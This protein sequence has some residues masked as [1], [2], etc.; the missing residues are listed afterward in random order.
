ML[1]DAQS[2]LWEGCEEHAVLSASLRALSLKIDYGLSQ[3]CFN[4]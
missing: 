1:K 2:P 4:E 3:G